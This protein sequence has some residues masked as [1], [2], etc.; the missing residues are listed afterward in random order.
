M[1]LSKEYSFKGVRTRLKNQY[2]KHA[3]HMTK[4]EKYRCAILLKK[5]LNDKGITLSKHCKERG[6]I[7]PMTQVIQTILSSSL[8]YHVIEYN[9]ASVDGKWWTQKVLFEIPKPMFYFC[10]RRNKKCLGKLKIVYDI[11]K[12]FIITAYY[13]DVNDNH[14]NLKEE[15]YHSDMYVRDYRVN[16][17]N[18]KNHSIKD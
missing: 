6:T 8:L 13:N 11:T 10:T 17:Y 16:G 5:A 12:G 2:R 9:E 15:F 7:V 1:A 18:S 14:D 4:S 3:N